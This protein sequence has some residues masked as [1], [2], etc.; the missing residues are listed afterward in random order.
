MAPLTETQKRYL[1]QLAHDQRP[2]VLIGAAGLSE[3]VVVELE[4]AIEHHELVKVK[5]RG[6]DRDEREAMITE[7]CRRTAAQLVQRIGH[8]VVLYRRHPQ[9][10]RIRLPS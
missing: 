10:P 9:K 8:T 7:M 1:R 4:T 3:A 6:A 2:V 5:I